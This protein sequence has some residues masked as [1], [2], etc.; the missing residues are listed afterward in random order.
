MNQTGGVYCNVSTCDAASLSCAICCRHA[1]FVRHSFRVNL[2]RVHA[3]E[4]DE[5]RASVAS[6]T[7]TINLVNSFAYVHTNIKTQFRL[8]I[9][10]TSSEFFT[11][12]GAQR[13]AFF[14]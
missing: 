6:Y 3:N 11:T 5:L 4:S 8:I 2:S 14:G 13:K 12:H 1:R 10:P 9:V 7:L